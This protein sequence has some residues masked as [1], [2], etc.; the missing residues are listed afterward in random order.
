MPIANIELFQ[1]DA[2]S[3]EKHLAIFL[4]KYTILLLGVEKTATMDFIPDRAL[5]NST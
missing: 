4:Q 3:W 2:D 1:I 5:T